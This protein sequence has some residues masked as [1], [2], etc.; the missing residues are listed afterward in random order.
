MAAAIIAVGIWLQALAGAPKSAQLL[1]IVG[2]VLALVLIWL[3]PRIAGR[4]AGPGV[5]WVVGLAAVGLLI[6]P[7]FQ[8]GIEGVHRWFWLGPVAIQPLPLALPLLVWL[9]AQE[10]VANA[11]WTAPGPI[12]LALAAVALAIQ[13]DQQGL[14]AI[15]VVSLAMLLPLDRL[16]GVKAARRWL[17]AALAFLALVA[18]AFRPSQLEPVAHVEEVITL[19]L[20]H[21][22]VTGALAVASVL[23]SIVLIVACAWV[24]T[25]KS[26]TGRPGLERIGLML[27][28]TWASLVAVSISN[29]FPVPVIGYGVSWVVG[30]GLTLGLALASRPCEITG[31]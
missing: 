19:A 9:A 7:L 22:P 26:T 15:L 20:R 8:P 5:R 14:I 1:Q 31:K 28:V 11:R 25:G 6:L 4:I 16:G 18:A 23:A 10:D 21:G 30:W 13:P 27:A 17:L 29:P 12:C 2:G 24:P 3:V